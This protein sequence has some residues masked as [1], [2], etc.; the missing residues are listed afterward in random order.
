MSKKGRAGI[1]DGHVIATITDKFGEPRQVVQ[2][3]S[4]IRIA[5][6]SI[7]PIMAMNREVAV[8]MGE[9]IKKARLAAGLTL[10]ECAIR[11]GMTSGWPKNRMYEIESGQRRTGIR[12]GTLYAVAAAIG[13]EVHELLPRLS[14]V[15]AEAEVKKATAKIVTLTHAGRV[16]DVVE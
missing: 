7:T 9:N 11:A 15:M 6:S 13:V 3:G 10:E 2:R 16:V 4:R 14:Q 12:F 5:N 8:M 1:V